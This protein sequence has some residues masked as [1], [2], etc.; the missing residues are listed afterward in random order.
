MVEK[1]RIS[2]ALIGDSEVGKTEIV[3]LIDAKAES[4]GTTYQLDTQQILYTVWELQTD[5]SEPER[6]E[7]FSVSFLK[8]SSPYNRFVIIVTDSSRE[9]SN[10]IRYS[11]KFLR[12]TFP[13]TRL[14]IIANKQDLENRI[15]AKQIEKM[16]KL[17]T[18]PLTAI[19]QT[20]RKRLLNFISYLIESDTGL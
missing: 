4:R 11:M 14:A 8:K 16:A 3:K 5:S 9:D 12:E 1:R 13:K 17:P 18:L 19:D 6:L 7:I 20:Q 10:K 15:S 2:L